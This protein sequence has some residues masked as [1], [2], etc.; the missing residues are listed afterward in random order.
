[1]PD[2]DPR[3]R[4]ARMLT[5]DDEPLYL[6]GNP[7]KEAVLE[8]IAEHNRRFVAR[9]PGGPGGCK[10][11]NIL[12]AEFFDTEVE[13]WNPQNAGKAINITKFLVKAE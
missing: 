7:S 9:E 10:A 3:L 1:M 4:V 12:T 6:R 2:K 11:R 8:F 5:H 13:S